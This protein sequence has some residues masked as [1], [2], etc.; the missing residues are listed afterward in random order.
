MNIR[1]KTNLLVKNFTYN[2][3]NK[4]KSLKISCFFKPRFLFIKLTRNCCLYVCKFLFYLYV[5]KIYIY[6]VI[7]LLLRIYF[8]STISIILIPY[9]TN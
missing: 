5:K 8:K 3:F 2:V 6:I 9:Y 1:M 4:C 7:N